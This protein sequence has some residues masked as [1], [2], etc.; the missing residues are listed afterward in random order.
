MLRMP[1]LVAD[2][3]AASGPARRRSSDL[4]ISD[5]GT[6]SGSRSSTPQVSM[7]HLALASHHLCA[8]RFGR[9]RR[10]DCLARS[11]RGQ[12]RQA[13]RAACCASACL[14]FKV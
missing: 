2:A 4:D 7:R 10:V 1:Q 14:G 13:A 3:N 11:E 9:K 12:E 6:P 8:E 5:A